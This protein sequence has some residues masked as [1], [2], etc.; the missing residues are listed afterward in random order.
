MRSPPL[1]ARSGPAPRAACPGSRSAEVL[2][3]ARVA[4]QPLEQRQVSAVAAR[5][6]TRSCSAG[7]RPRSSSPAT[8]ADSP[9][10]RRRTRSARVAPPDLGGRRHRRHPHRLRA[11]Q[12]GRRSARL[13]LDTV[14]ERAHQRCRV[15][16]LL[17]RPVVIE[18]AAAG[19]EWLHA[20]YEPHLDAFH[21]KACGFRPTN[22]RRLRLNH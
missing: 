12:L 20:D 5:A 17:L 7:G 22:A 3:R 21:C 15:G 19:C 8:S 4:H 11:R 6:A 18:V 1:T 9:S 2:G 14:V 16:R 10:A 13:L